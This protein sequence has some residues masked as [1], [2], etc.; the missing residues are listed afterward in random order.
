[1]HPDAALLAE[2]PLFKLLDD[3]E[4]AALAEHLEV[5]AHP[6][7]FLM[8]EYGDPGDS[9]YV[10][11]TGEV[12]MF[13]KDDTGGR[14]V[15]ECAK[16]GEH[17]GELSFLDEGCRSASVVVTKDLEAVR[18]D[19]EDLM[20][21]LKMKP[22]AALDLLAAMANR[23][24]Q[25]TDKLRHTASRNVNE[26]MN[27][28][29]TTVQKVADW[30]AEFSGSIPFLLIHAGLFTVWLVWNAFPKVAFDPYPYGLLTM[31][32]SLEA[33]FLSVFVLLSQNRQAAKDHVRSDIE[34]D[35]NLKAEL[36]VAQLHEKL[37]RL[38]SESLRRLR[39]IEERLV[40]HLSAADKVEGK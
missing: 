26:E 24:R 22:H 4:R 31:A 12:E 28:T 8:W 18:L 23:L 37:D 2:V 11:R 33:I 25:T 39:I 30:I 3:D 21:F 15:L 5:V 16:P 19:R 17:F 29:R 9:F 36:E 6:A 13:L 40:A 27:D 20:Q 38:H 10:I 35:V 7:G 32:V 1:M 34:Y 14:I